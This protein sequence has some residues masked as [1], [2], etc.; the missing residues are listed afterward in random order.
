MA[1]SAIAIPEKANRLLERANR[2]EAQFQIGGL[3]ESAL[4]LY[5]AVHQLLLAFLAVAT[6]ALGYVLDARGEDR[7]AIVAWVVSALNLVALVVSM[8]GSRELRRTLRSTR[9]K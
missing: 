1:M 8:S 4:L 5:A 9:K 7:L 2:G 6:G 3:R